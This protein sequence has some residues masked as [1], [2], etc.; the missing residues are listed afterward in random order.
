MGRGGGGG[1]RRRT[2]ARLS[3]G[4][5]PVEDGVEVA[6]P[7]QGT[8]GA[9]IAGSEAGGAERFRHRRR[10]VAGSNVSSR[11]AVRPARARCSVCPSPP[12]AAVQARNGSSSPQR[13]WSPKCGGML[14]TSWVGRRAIG[15]RGFMAFFPRLRRMSRMSR[16]GSSLRSRP[17]SQVQ[18]RHRGPAGDGDGDDSPPRFPTCSRSAGCRSRPSP[19]GSRRSCLLADRVAASLTE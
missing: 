1:R 17:C 11:P 6:A 9:A 5:R 2:R 3:G 10:A 13:S 19:G 12:R 8:E 14:T 4:H 18:H 16:F 7:R 15:A